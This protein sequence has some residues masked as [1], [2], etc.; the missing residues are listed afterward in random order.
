MILLLTYYDVRLCHF[1]TIMGYSDNK[2]LF[3]RI[4]TSNHFNHYMIIKYMIF[5]HIIYV[6]NL[7]TVLSF[8]VFNEFDSMFLCNGL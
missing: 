5:E 1:A 3:D 2:T 4:E 6:N 8:K 7:N